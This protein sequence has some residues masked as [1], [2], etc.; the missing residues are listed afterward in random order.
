MSSGIL[1][2]VVLLLVIVAVFAGVAALIVGLFFLILRANRGHSQA[3]VEGALEHWAAAEGFRIIMSR[4]ADKTD[5]HPFQDRFGFGIRKRGD[6]GGIVRRIVVEDGR[7][8]ERS[9]WL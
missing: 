8:R 2:V 5:D 7:R 6:Y 9:G 3:V 1:V 4:A